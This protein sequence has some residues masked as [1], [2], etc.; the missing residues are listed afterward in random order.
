MNKRILA[1]LLVLLIGFSRTPVY[2]DEEEI[3]TSIR[4]GLFYDTGAKDRYTIGS[5]GIF[6]VGIRHKDHRS[7]ALIFEGQEFEIIDMSFKSL[8]IHPQR[9]D[10]AM[11]AYEYAKKQHGLTHLYFDG[12][13][14]V[15]V[16]D[17]NGR[18][19]PTML[20]KGIGE[21]SGV[22]MPLAEDMP[23]VFEIDGSNEK[24]L[25]LNGQRYRGEIELLPSTSYGITVV[26]HL[27]LEDYLYGVL[28]KEMPTSWHI[29]ALKAQAVAARTYA[30]KNLGKWSKYGFDLK[31]DTGDQDYAG[32]DAENVATNQAVD[33]TK[34][35]MLLF[36][37]EPIVAFYH[38]DSG[39]ITEACSEAF[40][41]DLPYLVSVKDE[42]VKGSPNSSWEMP[43]VLSSI[44]Q[45]PEVQ[46]WGIGDIKSLEIT[47]RT[48]AGRVK[49]MKLIGSHGQVSLSY[50]QLRSILSLKSNLFDIFPSAN[51][52]YDYIVRGSGYG[53]GVGMSQWGAK[54]MAEEGYNYIAILQHYYRHT[55]ISDIDI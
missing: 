48:N 36:D 50:S 16:E 28:P 15:A 31:G 12:S 32:F 18:P 55:Q 54:A 2:A 45:R 44:S 6:S 22:V 43:L 53:H 34:G 49:E 20:L 51:G 46:Q 23:I 24:F 27:D 40:G 14:G 29:E 26:N 9:F 17:Y 11:D 21:D 41:S 13:W 19:S 33:E 8:T 42:F 47:K 25:M 35:Q 5:E 7:L 52:Q 3:S 37:N 38:A 4:I 10:N 1:I 30:V 39:G